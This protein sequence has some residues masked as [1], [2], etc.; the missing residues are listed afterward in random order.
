MMTT[1]S[2]SVEQKTAL[3]RIDVATVGWSRRVSETSLDSH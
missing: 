3:V 1:A 2:W